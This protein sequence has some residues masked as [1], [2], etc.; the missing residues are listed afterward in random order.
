L[1]TSGDTYSQNAKFWIQIIREKLDRYRTD[2]TDAVVLAALGDLE[3]K[4]ILDGGCGEGYLSR[5]IH[6]RGAIVT[7]LDVSASLIEAATS[8]RDRLKLTRLKHY[9]AG[10]EAIPEDD[11]TFDAV[12][13][14]HV[15]TDVEDAA[16]A[17]K[18][19]SR[20]TKIGGKLVILML[21]PC[22]YTAHAERNASGSIP[23]DRY[24]NTRNISQNFKVAGV[25][26]PDK[27]HMNF[28]PLEYHTAAILQSGYV[29]T[30]LSEPHPSP[31]QFQ[32]AWWRENFVKPLF[33]LIVAE[34]VARPVG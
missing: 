12:V 31:E 2:L 5:E 11:A 28:R 18:E 14:N 27:V 15:M 13:C 19:I 17:L 7:G 29:I 22:F 30:H 25:S 3:G 20:V 8:E 1:A 9:V 26:S 33:M 4:N 16:E 10:L 24:F 23:V 34:R 21:H 6:Q 32:D